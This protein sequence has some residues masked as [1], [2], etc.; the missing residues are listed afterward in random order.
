ML[1]DDVDHY[2][3]LYIITETNIAGLLTI[4]WLWGHKYVFQIEFE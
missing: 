4:G 2:S 3:A 1:L